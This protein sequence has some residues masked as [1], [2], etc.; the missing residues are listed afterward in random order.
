MIGVSEIVRL[1][2]IPIYSTSN[3]SI[4]V[5]PRCSEGLLTLQNVGNIISWALNHNGG[6]C[7]G[8]AAEA[9]V[10]SVI[11]GNFVAVPALRT[12]ER[13]EEQ[14]ESYHFESDGQD[15]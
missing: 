5:C 10:G 9:E 1:A 14:A 15:K 11:E 6:V 4:I 3:P 13:Q 8:E 7:Y 12:P 2:E